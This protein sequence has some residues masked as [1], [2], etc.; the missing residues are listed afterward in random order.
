MSSR[1]NDWKLLV[2]TWFHFG[3]SAFIA[4]NDGKLVLQA[5]EGERGNF[6]FLLYLK[7]SATALL[8]LIRAWVSPSGT[9]CS[10]TH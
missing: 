2:F 5:Q 10:L 6:I 9:T 4:Q 7:N 8:G 1:K 3:M